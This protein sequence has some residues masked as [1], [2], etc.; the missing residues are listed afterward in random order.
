MS[1][2]LFM[3]RQ[4]ILNADKELFAYELFYRNDEGKSEIDDP[5]EAT[6]SVLVNV[7]NQ[8]GLQGSVGEFKA[9]VNVGANILLTEILYSL[10]KDTF[11]FELSAD[12]I[13]TN[14]EHD[15][16]KILHQQGYVFALDNIV[17]KDAY[18]ENFSR[19]FP[20][21]TYA[22]FD[23]T[24]TDIELLEA[25]IA[26]YQDMTLIAQRVEIPEVFE[27]Y[28]ELGFSYFQG[29]FFAAPHL[30]QQ[31]RLDPKHLGVI[32]IF[33]LLQQ[34]APLPELCD[35]FE[36][37]NELTLQLLQ[38]LNS[39]SMFDIHGSHSIRDIIAL[40]GKQRL[41]QWLL[42][43]IYSKSGKDIKTS[44][45][46]LSLLV[47]NRI[48]IML[49]LIDIINPL[50]KDEMKEQARFLAL[51]SLLETVFN[52]PT[53][54]ILEKFE[55]SEVIYAALTSHT[56]KLGRLFA[57]SLSIERSDFAATQI[58]LKSYKLN[59]DDIDDIIAISMR[60]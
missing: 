13:I 26:I 50:N 37:H 14:K 55:V 57:L 52:V 42:L 15:A 16:I 29:Y 8:I 10:P 9:F 11:V 33:N 1:N 39:T 46:P 20:Y 60:F 56:G 6:S 34:D 51:I 38:F 5:R 27:A 25:N 43:I 32:R 40:V 4:P 12:I 19:I 22:K 21:I 31:N 24:H 47:Q 7:L 49:G 18:F 58:L 54:Y 17:F 36:K 41:L 59:I 3:A 35:E 44:K 48:D 30:I 28:K 45:S 53:A 2:Q 23:T